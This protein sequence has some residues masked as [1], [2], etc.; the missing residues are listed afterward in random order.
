MSATTGFIDS[1]SAR[2]GQGQRSARLS[3]GHPPLAIILRRQV[4][5]EKGRVEFAADLETASSH[6]LGLTPAGYCDVARVAG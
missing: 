1:I 5:M 4:K 3:F 2:A 6:C